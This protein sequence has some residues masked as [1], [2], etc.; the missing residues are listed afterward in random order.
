MK[1]TIALIFLLAVLVPL[2]EWST[3]IWWLFGILVGCLYGGL[4]TADRALLISLSPEGFLGES[5]GFYSLMARLAY[6]VGT[7]VW[8]I[9]SDA[10]AQGQIMAV[11]TLFLSTLMGLACVRRISDKSL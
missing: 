8:A 3:D 7:F 4:W 11:F 9:L 6:L 10:F 5:F 1:Q 2:F